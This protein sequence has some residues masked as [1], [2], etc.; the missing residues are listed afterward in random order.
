VVLLDVERP[1][2][3]HRDPVLQALRRDV[4]DQVA[5]LAVVLELDLL[6][7]G[8]LVQ[9]GEVH[10]LDLG[11][12]DGLGLRAL[13][14]RGQ[15]RLELGHLLRGQIGGQA[16][17][18]ERDDLEVARRDGRAVLAR[19]GTLVAVAELLAVPERLALVELVLEALLV[20]LRL[21]VR[22]THLRQAGR[23][24]P[25]ILLPRSAGVPARRGTGLLLMFVRTG[26]GS[27]RLPPRAL[28]G[29]R[30]S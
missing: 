8:D 27:A 3:D 13:G 15:R 25:L 17:D 22:R 23:R 9:V 11:V 26:A 19:R 18:V 30:R 4:P 1:L 7:L 29:P 6:V 14:R 20:L 5:P 28:R 2:D 24:R 12:R 16:R 10:R 21:R